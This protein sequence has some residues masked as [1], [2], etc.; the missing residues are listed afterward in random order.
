MFSFGTTFGW[1][2]I[3]F[4]CEY[5]VFDLLSHV[6]EDFQDVFVL[7]GTDLKEFDTK[8]LSETFTLIVGDA[9]IVAVNF[10][11]DKDFYYIL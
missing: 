9:S 10:V 5:F 11:G 4:T 2:V 7:F 3:D 8:A 6:H 1:D